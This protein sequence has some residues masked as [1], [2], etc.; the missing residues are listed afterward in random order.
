M[1]EASAEAKG[2]SGGTGA[3]VNSGVLE[4]TALGGSVESPGAAQAAATA[5]GIVAGS[6]G[7]VSQT[8]LIRVRAVAGTENGNPSR[9]TAYGVYFENG[10][11]LYATGPILAEASGGAPDQVAPVYAAAPSAG[12][13]PVTIRSYNLGL[14]GNTAST[15]GA[16]AGA[17][18]VLDNAR[19][20]LRPTTGLRRDAS[21]A[22]RATTACSPATPARS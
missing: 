6:G 1:S 8:G 4:V 7:R 14:G 9:A 13:T 20:I 3:F 21:T 18:F 15:F 11:S 5:Y 22:S 2:L 10:G 16:A 17:G 19:F 12:G